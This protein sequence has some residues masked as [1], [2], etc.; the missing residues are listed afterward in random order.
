MTGIH[1]EDAIRT[2][3]ERLKHAYSTTRAPEE[4]ERAIAQARAAFSDRPVRDFLP[5]LVERRARTILDE[6]G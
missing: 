3:T 2:V 5:V 4:V 1:E 6:A